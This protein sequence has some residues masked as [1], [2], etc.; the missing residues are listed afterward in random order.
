[1]EGCNLTMLVNNVGK[2]SPTTVAN[3]IDELL[4]INIRFA[5]HLTSYRLPRLTSKALLI[6]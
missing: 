5:A 6:I 2:G 3:E 1:M 4:N